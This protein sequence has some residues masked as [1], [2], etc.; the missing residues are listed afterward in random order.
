MS[1]V[2]ADIEAYILAQKASGKSFPFGEDVAVYKVLDKMFAL[3]SEKGLNLKCNPDDAL[4]WR[5]MYD[6]IKPAYHM[7][8]EHWNTI[9]LDDSV[10]QELIYKMIDD[11]Y[12]LVV[13]KMRKMDR[14]K[15]NEH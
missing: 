4:L 5:S 7:N 10:P 1:I 9:I 14:D 3:I 13:K 15:L 12:A 6:A 8:K 2:L 11:S